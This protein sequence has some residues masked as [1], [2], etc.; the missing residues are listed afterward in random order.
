M[1]VSRFISCF[2]I[3]GILIAVPL[4]SPAQQ[5]NAPENSAR[6]RQRPPGILDNPAVNGFALGGPVGVLTDEQRASYEAA[7][8]KERGLMVELQNRLRVARQEFVEASVGQ[9]FDE[10]SLRQ[11]A[12]AAT[13]LEAEMAVLRAKALSQVQPPLTQEQIQKIKTSQPGPVR[14][15]RQGVR[16]ALQPPPATASTNQDANGLPPK[17]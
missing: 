16:P 10:N 12:L 4:A 6:F 5:T 17:K 8:N 13:R 2:L 1:K 9:T 11:K 3:P 7:L 15:L 14:P